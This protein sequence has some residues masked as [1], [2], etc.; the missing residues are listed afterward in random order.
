[1]RNKL[2]PRPPATR[3]NTNPSSTIE[4]L[5]LTAAEAA[6]LL[7]ISERTLWEFSAPRGPIPCVRSGAK[8]GLV[9]YSRRALEEWIASAERQSLAEAGAA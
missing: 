4:P 3:L 8:G 9:R 5:L 6:E 1:M 7:N 2:V